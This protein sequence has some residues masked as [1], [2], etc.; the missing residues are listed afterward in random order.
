MPTLIITNNAVPKEILLSPGE[1]E[2]VKGFCQSRAVVKLFPAILYP[3][4]TQNYKS[5]AE[6]LLA[7]TLTNYAL[8]VNN[9]VLKIFAIIGAV[10][11]DLIT[12]PIRQFAIIPRFIINDTAVE[13]PLHLFLRKKGIEDFLYAEKVQVELEWT[14][15]NEGDL[16]FNPVHHRKKMNV[17]FVEVPF[18]KDHDLIEEF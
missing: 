6:D 14:E 11:L 1:L 10:L 18:Y 15:E 13:H 9:I 12:L 5:F 16:E 2:L 17:N 8:K 3:V 7:P 4:R